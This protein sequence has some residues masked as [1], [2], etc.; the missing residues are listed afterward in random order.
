LYASEILHLAGIHP[1]RPADRLTPARIERL[2]SA[3]T[4]ILETAIR[5]EGSTLSD[6]TYRNALN[7]AGGYQ[8]AHRVYD[9]EHETCP[10]CQG[11][12]IRRIV[13][14]QRSTFFCK[15]CQK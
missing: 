10:T 2:A 5:Y 13:Q 8:N 15:A 3:V 14:A 7:E 4:V 9:R 12:P 6:G 11:P 1:A